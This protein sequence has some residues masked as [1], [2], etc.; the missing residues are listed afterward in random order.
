MVYHI[1]LVILVLFLIYTLVF[2]LFL[3]KSADEYEKVLDR[4]LEPKLQEQAE[5]QLK[6]IV[7]SA[8][9]FMN[10]FFDNLSQLITKKSLIIE[11]AFE[12]FEPIQDQRPKMLS[13]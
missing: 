4:V 3:H 5:M 10:I 2:Q 1:L 11:Q 7:S 12:N 13:Q 6:D 9:L 8:C